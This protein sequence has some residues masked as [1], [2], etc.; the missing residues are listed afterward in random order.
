MDVGLLL[1]RSAG[2]LADRARA[3]ILRAL[4]DGGSLTATELSYRAGVSPQTTSSHL[5]KLVQAK[6]LAVEV[7][8][9][10]RHYRLA[11]PNVGHAVEALLAVAWDGEERDEGVTKEIEPIRVARTCYDH[12]AG[13]LGVALTQMMVK[14]K[15]LKPRGRDFVLTAPGEAF[16]KKLGVDMEKAKRQRRAF[17]RQCLDWTERRPHLAGALGAAFAARWVELG[18]VIRVSAG[19]YLVVTEGGRR[20]LRQRFSVKPSE[21]FV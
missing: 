8:G 12:L 11:R 3:K 14:R 15:Y 19:R 10:Y 21:V 2:L 18:W 5:A 6:L 1:A 17:A 7:E 9:R 16:L 20:A 13:K 4:T